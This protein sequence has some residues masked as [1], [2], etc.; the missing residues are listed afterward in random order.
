ME[1]KMNDK[2]IQAEIDWADAFI[3][4]LRRT[5]PEQQIRKSLELLQKRKNSLQ[6]KLTHNVDLV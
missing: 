1:V 6:N 3:E 2:K 4:H 5:K